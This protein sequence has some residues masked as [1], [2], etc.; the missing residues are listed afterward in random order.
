MPKITIWVVPLTNVQVC[1]TKYANT[2]TAM[3]NK[4][5]Y[6]AK[7]LLNVHHVGEETK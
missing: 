6:F 3:I 2:A 5:V 4:A 7:S 1:G